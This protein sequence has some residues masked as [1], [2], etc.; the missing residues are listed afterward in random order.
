MRL[1]TGRISLDYN[2]FRCFMK[3]SIM[4]SEILL[5]RSGTYVRVYDLLAALPPRAYSTMPQPT[6]FKLLKKKPVTVL[7][8]FDP[9]WGLTDEQRDGKL[10]RWDD[11]T[12][13]ELV[14]KV[15]YSIIGGHT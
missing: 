2:L 5:V 10:A 12:L 7:W 3:K 11:D 14:T 13:G 1:E 9:D 6:S 8:K 4:Y 15:G